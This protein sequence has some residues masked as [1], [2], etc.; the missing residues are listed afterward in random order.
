ML[1]TQ[2]PLHYVHSYCITIIGCTVWKVPL[3]STNIE[4]G[5]LL[6]WVPPA[7]NPVITWPPVSSPSS[8]PRGS[9]SSWKTYHADTWSIHTCGFQEIL[10]H[11]T[12]GWSNNGVFFEC[13]RY[14]KGDGYETQ[15]GNSLLH[16]ASTEA[17]NN[18]MKGKK[19]YTW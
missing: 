3:T 19:N 8:V 12:S 14:H 18:H 9:Q 5:T 13:L 11:G 15:G 17:K 1:S 7:R 2:Q 6:V 16:G 10:P 4:R